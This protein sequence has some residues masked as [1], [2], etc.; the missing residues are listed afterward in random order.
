MRRVI[1]LVF[2]KNQKTDDR[3]GCEGWIFRFLKTKQMI[4]LGAKVGGESWVRKLGAE[5]GAK[6]KRPQ[7]NQI[8]SLIFLTSFSYK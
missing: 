6:K 5:V 7:V 4:V 1:F 2:L 8:W 3:V